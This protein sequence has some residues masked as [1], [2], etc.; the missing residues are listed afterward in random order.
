MS[1][2]GFIEGVG[3]ALAGSLAVALVWTVL[4]PL[5]PFA[6]LARVLVSALAGGYLLY[7]LT[8]GSLRVGRVS[9]V[10]AWLA[11]TGGLMVFDPPL[12]V[13]V[14]AQAGA[15]WLV[16]ACAFHSG[17]L[18]A[19]ADLGLVGAGLLTAA[20]AMTQTGNAALAAWCL[21]L[22][23]APFACLPRRG[24]QTGTGHTDPGV[25]EDPF[26]RAHRSAEQAL[27]RPASIR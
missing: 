26:E 20:W 16:R 5:L 7:L 22:V 18:T 25:A 13:H 11:M 17:V 6:L 4:L 12:S 1:R 15:V 8:R 19:L 21:L 14:L 27:G 24:R 10:L 23:Q 2:P 3:V 9:G